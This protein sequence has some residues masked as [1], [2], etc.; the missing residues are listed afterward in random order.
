MV[1][2]QQRVMALFRDMKMN[3]ML[4]GLVMMVFFQQVSTFKIAII[5]NYFLMLLLPV[6]QFKTGEIL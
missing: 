4:V 5:I 3:I 6:R 1:M 2:E